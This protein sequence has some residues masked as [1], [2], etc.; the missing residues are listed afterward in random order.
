VIDVAERALPLA[1][2]NPLVCVAAY[3]T[4]VAHRRLPSQDLLNRLRRRAFHSAPGVRFAARAIA[5]AGRDP[6]GFTA[7][8][9]D[10]A[11]PVAALWGDHDAL[12][13]RAHIPA[14]E[15]ALPQAH[16]EVWE[17]MGHHPQRERPGRLARFIEAHAAQARRAPAAA[18]RRAA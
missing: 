2:L 1:L 13:P 18:A 8:A 11:G 15:R 12:V 10:F 17:G 6:D 4:F 5:H 16:V 7:R 14:L 3:S 9:I